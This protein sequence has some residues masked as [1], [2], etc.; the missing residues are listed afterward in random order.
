MNNTTSTIRNTSSDDLLNIL[1]NSDYNWLQFVNLAREN[2]KEL[3]ET[4][5]QDSISDFYNKL[6]SLGMSNSDMQIVQQ[7]HQV[8]IL[9]KS[10]EERDHAI[11][12]GNIV[13][14]SDESSSDNDIRKIQRS[15]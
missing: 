7:S 14:E 11:Q 3:N 4:A 1:K 12:S 6:P 5:F 9:N 15:F 13:S 2:M 8:Y 10:M